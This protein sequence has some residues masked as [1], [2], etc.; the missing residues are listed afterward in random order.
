MI[1][2]GQFL[3]L[4]RCTSGVAAIEFAMIG[5]LLITLLIGTFELGRALFIRN[6]LAF[7][8]DIATRQILINPAVTESHLEA[9]IRDAITFADDDLHVELGSQSLD[10][11]SFRTISIRQPVMLLVPDL[12]QTIDLTVERQVP[13]R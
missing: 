4:I 3:R 5:L 12:Q 9:I 11:I 10:G 1:N 6:Q 7:A 2:G 8:A 13:L